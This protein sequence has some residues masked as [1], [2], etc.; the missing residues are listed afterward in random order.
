MHYDILYLPTGRNH[1]ARPDRSW[2]DPNSGNMFGDFDVPLM[3]M[4]LGEPAMALDHV[5]RS[6]K[7]NFI[8]LTWAILMPAL[9]PIRCEPRFIAAVVRTGVTDARAARLCKT[10]GV[11]PAKEGA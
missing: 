9:D 7:G 2:R 4:L 6:S 5:E 8:D 3:L 10:T 11:E 1:H